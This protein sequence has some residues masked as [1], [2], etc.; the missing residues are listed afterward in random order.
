MNIFES[1]TEWVYQTEFYEKYMSKWAPPLNDPSLILTILIFVLVITIAVSVFNH[2]RN[3]RSLQRIR[4]KNLEYQEKVL[5]EKMK[6]SQNADLMDQYMKFMMIAQMKQ[7]GMDVSFE[8]FK[9]AKM[10]EAASTEPVAEEPVK[11]EKKRL[12]LS[13]A[14]EAVKHI[15]KHKDI[16][17]PEEAP[18]PIQVQTP[19]VE[20]KEPELELVPE[21]EPEGEPIPDTPEVQLE[22]VPVE[23][24]VLEEVPEE[25]PLEPV[26]EQEPVVDDEIEGIELAVE[27]EEVPNEPEDLALLQSLRQEEIEEE[28]TPDIADEELHDLNELLAKKTEAEGLEPVQVT[29]SDVNDFERLLN[30]MRASQK[31][32]EANAEIEREKAEKI[33]ANANLTSKK[34]SSLLTSVEKE[35]DKK[36]VSS[37]KID[38]LDSAKQAALK[39]KE[40]EEEKRRKLEEK[41]N[42]RKK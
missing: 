25:I 3:Y 20:E 23:E 27:L 35:T 5:D 7:V 31:A 21:P 37:Q 41:K 32:R 42:R 29:Q 36:A 38:S 6:Q 15:K 24:P 40:R 2:I 12:D 26:K 10:V 30:N 18:E 8:D 22:E 11:P 34:I 13:S 17:V 16:K 19:I 33:Q 39:Q 28:K 9:A 1:L 14:L 4:K